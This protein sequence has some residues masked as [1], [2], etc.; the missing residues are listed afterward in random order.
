MKLEY[1]QETKPAA[2]SQQYPSWRTRFVDSVYASHNSAKAIQ[3]ALGKCLSRLQVEDVGLNV[4]AGGT[5]I[6]PQV[7]NLD[8]NPGE[9]VDYCGRAEDLPFEDQKFSLVVT[10]EV[11][12]HVQFPHQAVAEMF[13]VLRPGGTLYCQLPF[14]IGFHPCPTDYWRF[15]KQ[16]I[17][18]L[19][20]QGGFVCEEVGIAV[21]PGTGFYRIAVEF[22]AAVA[23][24]LIS[25]L[26]MPTKA[27]AAILLYPLKSLDHLLTRNAAIDRISG[28]YYVIARKK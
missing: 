9:N 8:L 27:M 5:R 16:G 13:R 3:Q 23:G 19:L 11:L 24:S 22:F 25:K 12:E 18:E 7:L 20:E 26:Y 14:V 1:L 10:Q 4:G 6:H 2:V 28:G 21:G 15:T 17:Q